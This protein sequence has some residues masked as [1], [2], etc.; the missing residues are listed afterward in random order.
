MDADANLEI[1]IELRRKK[2]LS[3]LDL[4]IKQFFKKVSTIS[5]DVATV[6]G[7]QQDVYQV[8]TLATTTSREEWCLV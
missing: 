1:G 8:D 7:L 6:R 3:K 2:V 5:G 4:F